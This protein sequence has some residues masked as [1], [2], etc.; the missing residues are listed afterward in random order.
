MAKKSEVSI[1][2]SRL[3]LGIAKILEQEKFIDAVEEVPTGHGEI[4]IKLKYDKGRPVIRSIK[5]ISKPGKRVYVGSDNLPKVLND[6]G[7]AI[8]STSRGLM[9]NKNARKENLGG[10][11][12]CEIF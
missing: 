5:R 1:P 3:K 7:I 9:T 11:V 12:I 10:E 8:I 2:A 4:V 6:F